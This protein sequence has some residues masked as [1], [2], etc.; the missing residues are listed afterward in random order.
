MT[1]RAAAA[2]VVAQEQNHA[3]AVIIP[4]QYSDIAYHP[5]RFCMEKGR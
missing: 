5:F 4:S 3:A 2:M 1:S